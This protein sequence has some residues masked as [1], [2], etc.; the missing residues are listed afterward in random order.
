MIRCK[1]PT[2]DHHAGMQS[3]NIE[4]DQPLTNPEGR[5]IGLQHHQR[6]DLQS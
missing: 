4:Y 3:E 1:A 6:N 5:R 2:P